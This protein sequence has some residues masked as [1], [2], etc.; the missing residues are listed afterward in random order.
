MGARA[1]TVR[2]KAAHLCEGP[3]GIGA[4][5]ERT[6]V[7]VIREKAG[8]GPRTGRS[9]CGRTVGVVATIGYEGL[10][11]RMPKLGWLMGRGDRRA[12]P[13]SCSP[14]TAGNACSG[15]RC[16]HG[17]PL[18]FLGQAH[19][20]SQNVVQVTEVQGDKMLAH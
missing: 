17:A 19:E 8:R 11:E 15:H 13:M 14:L 6:T 5:F 20:P 3:L 10:A 9:S 4:G 18:N 2:L 7:G 12:R 16:S 1:H